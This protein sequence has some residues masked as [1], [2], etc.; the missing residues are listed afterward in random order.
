[1]DINSP[2]SAS[3]L[4]TRKLTAY[5]F[6]LKPSTTAGPQYTLLSSVVQK[7]DIPIR[8]ITPLVSLIVSTE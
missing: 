4:K 5:D 3:Q 6:L 1:M 8:R 2:L 7:V